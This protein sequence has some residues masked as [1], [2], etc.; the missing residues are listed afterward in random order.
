MASLIGRMLLAYRP[1]YLRG[2]L[3]DGQYRIPQPSP[4]PAKP[5]KPSTEVVAKRAP[6]RH[7]KPLHGATP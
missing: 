3:M 6:S 2:L 4:A 7:L 1:L 5:V